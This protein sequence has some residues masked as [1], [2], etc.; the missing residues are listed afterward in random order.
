MRWEET[1]TV[2][3]IIPVFSFGII[4]PAIGLSVVEESVETA[5]KAIE[6]SLCRMVINII[7]LSEKESVFLSD[8][9]T[10][11]PSVYLLPSWRPHSFVAE[12]QYDMDELVE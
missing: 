8:Q 6:S 12:S 10:Q 7:C 11:K 3:S 5:F 4:K 2:V 1:I 9:S